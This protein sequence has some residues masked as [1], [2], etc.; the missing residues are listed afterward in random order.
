MPWT[1]ISVEQQRARFLAAYLHSLDTMT[2]LCDRFGVSR[3]TGYKWVK[4]F[5]VSGELEDRSSRPLSHPTKTPEWIEDAIVAASKQYPRLGPKKL[6]ALF[7]R[8]NPSAD[9][10]SPSTFA[11]IFKRNGLVK[12]RK[13]RGGNTPP[14]S[15]PFASAAAPNSVWCIDFKGHFAVGSTRCYP[16]T[17]MDAYSRYLLGCVALTKP[18]GLHVAREMRRLFERFGLPEA[19]RTDNGPPFASRGLAG[20]TKL[21]VWW[22]KLG[23]RHERIEKGHPEQNGRHERMH[24][25]LKQY[26]ASPPA[27][28]RRAQQ[29]RFDFFRHEYN[30]ERPHEALAQSFPAEN[31]HCSPRIVP[32]LTQRR[33]VVYHERF[34]P[35]RLSDKGRLEWQGSSLFLSDSLAGELVGI[36]WTDDRNSVNVYFGP[37]RLGTICRTGRRYF[38]LKFL[39]ERTVSPMS[40]V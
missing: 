13:R 40:M 22:T 7:A 17:V 1:E 26:T 11:A 4:R 25:T 2:F 34:Q 27:S 10:P 29:R 21:S 32:D 31:Y 5:M 36:E 33:D 9:L 12:P 14:F 24:L 28:S 35:I 15:A 20:L 19:I 18:D 8:R 3:K 38:K 39:A 37:I 23:I 6:H 30:D 16:L